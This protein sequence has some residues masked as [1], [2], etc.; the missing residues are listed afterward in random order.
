MEIQDRRVAVHTRQLGRCSGW[1][2]RN[3]QPQ[4]LQLNTWKEPTFPSCLI[5]LTKI[6]FL[7]YLCQP[8][9][10]N[11]SWVMTSD[12]LDVERLIMSAGG[13]TWHGFPEGS[14]IG[15]V[16]LQV[17]AIAPAE[18]FYAGI[19]GLH[20]TARYPGGT[21]YADGTY[22]H[23]LAT[24]IWNSRGAS[25]RI[26]PS[27]GLADVE[28]VVDRA[29]LDAVYAR[30]PEPTPTAIDSPQRLSLRDPWGTSITLA[31]R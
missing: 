23:H 6:A 11:G 28:M 8:Q 19:L 1:N 25:V 13:Q 27:T 10:E 2:T 29:M 22:H 4:K 5:H 18:A 14:V 31:A 24:N 12:P 20:V 7:S 21:F 26:E 3:K 17:G 9:K 30:L 15:H 16:H